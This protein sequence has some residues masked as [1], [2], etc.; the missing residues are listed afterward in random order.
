M[1]GLKS[2]FPITLAIGLYN[3]LYY[4]TSCDD[5]LNSTIVSWKIYRLCLL[6]LSAAFDII[7][8]N[9]LPTHLSSLFGILG[10]ALNWSR[11]YLSSRCF[12]VKCNNNLSS[13]HICLSGVPK[14]QFLAFWPLLFVM[15]TTML[16]TLISFLSLNHH[17]HADNIQLFLSFHPSEFHSNITHLQNA[18]QQISSWMTGNLLT[19]N[20]SKTWVSSYHT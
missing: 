16:S 4:R 10:T 6:D 1:G 11:S 18:L 12:C 2:P 9:F 3:S 5:H 20:T 13:V 7:D 15:Y 14:A 17:V 8:H 19:V